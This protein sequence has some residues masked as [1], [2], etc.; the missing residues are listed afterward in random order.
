MVY[1]QD[2]VMAINQPGNWKTKLF[3]RFD[4]ARRAETKNIR[5]NSSLK[6]EFQ[7][8]IYEI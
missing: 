4:S 5:P 6:T 1:A 8:S 3:H 7:N 2:G